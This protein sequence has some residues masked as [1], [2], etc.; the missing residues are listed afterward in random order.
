MTKYI[1]LLA[2][3]AI[4][5]TNGYITDIKA[6][7]QRG[8]VY[9]TEGL[10]LWELDSTH[11][12]QHDAHHTSG[13]VDYSSLFV[14]NHGNKAALYAYL[15]SGS[16]QSFSYFDLPLS[17][18]DAITATGS[19]SLPPGLSH[20]PIYDN[21][22][23]I[24]VLSVSRNLTLVNLNTL[25]TLDSFRYYGNR[26]FGINSVYNHQN[27]RL[28]VFHTAVPVR[29][30]YGLS[31]DEYDLSTGK[32][33][34][35]PTTYNCECNEPYNITASPFFKVVLDA[36]DCAID[37]K[38]TPPRIWCGNGEGSRFFSFNA[39]NLS[40]YKV[41]HTSTPFDSVAWDFTNNFAY[42]IFANGNDYS[43]VGFSVSKVHMSNGAVASTYHNN[44]HIIDSSVFD[45]DALEPHLYL[46]VYDETAGATTKIVSVNTN[47]MT[48][49]QTVV[50]TPL[51]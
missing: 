50:L 22:D 11:L 1:L 16:A 44:Q 2:L 36:G 5:F 30:N 24:A 15:D 3:F 4:S 18:Q 19:L 39:A 20:P 28:S 21:T 23:H 29:G 33:V 51:P 7:K 13:G 25:T 43:T 49:A 48:T 45:L 31:V 14:G 47:L 17:S 40:D 37:Y 35:I 27:N 41:I 26:I 34:E 38:T 10:N 6:D 8:L 32:F 42:T 12:T 46:A 9:V